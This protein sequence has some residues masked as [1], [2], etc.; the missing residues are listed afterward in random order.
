[1]D[2]RGW[3][4]V[5]YVGGNSWPPFVDAPEPVYRVRGFNGYEPGLY[6][7]GGG[8]PL[9]ITCTRAEA[10]AWQ[11]AA[12]T[13]LDGVRAAEEEFPRPMLLGAGWV[14]RVFSRRTRAQWRASRRAMESFRDRWRE[15]DAGYRPVRE[16]IAARR[17]EALQRR[18]EA[19]SILQRSA[20]EAA[21]AVWGYVATAGS[22]DRPA[23]FAYRHDVA[24]AGEP[25]AATEADQ[26]ARS[27]EPLRALDLGAAVVAVTGIDHPPIDWD[28]NARAATEAATG[29]PFDQWWLAHGGAYRRRQPGRDRPGTT[30]ASTHHSSH[31]IGYHA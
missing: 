20:A 14:A 21:R 4:S 2:D 29:R 17:V 25:P 12:D 9:P 28:P 23:V 10:E 26:V 7:Y 6:A 19:D 31:G 3:V 1:M 13:V 24:P 5:E 11:A 30:H 22:G 15:L 8:G 16:V 18:E 27:T